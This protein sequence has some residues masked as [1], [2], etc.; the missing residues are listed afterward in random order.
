MAAATALLDE[1]HNPLQQNSRDHNTYTLGRIGRHNVVL[2]CLPTGVAGTLSAARVANQMLRT[3]EGIRFGLMVGIGGGVPSEEN[4]IRL[5]DIVVSKPT[6]QSGGVIQYDF[7]KTVQDGRFERTGSLKRPPDVLLTALAN[8]QSKHMMEGHELAKYL[9]EMLRRYPKMA[10]QFALPDMQLDSLYDAEY[11]HIKEYATCSQCNVSRLMD[12]EPRPSEDPFIH[13]GLIAS[14]DQVMRDG[15][16]RER[17]RK[18]LDV[19]CFEMEAAGLMDEFPCLVVRGICDY[20]DSHKN[21]QWQGYAA[22]TAAAYAKEL[23]SVIT[24]NLVVSTCAAVETTKS[25]Y[26]GSEFEEDGTIIFEK[27][28]QR[29]GNLDD[30]NNAISIGEEAVSATPLD[31]P[32]RAGRLSN[33]AIFRQSRFEQTR[34]L[35]DLNNAISIGEEAVSATPLDHPNRAGRLSNLAVFR[36]SRFELTGNF[37]DLQ[38]A[39]SRAKEAVSATPLDHPDR[40]RMLTNLASLLY[41]RYNRSGTLSDLQD[42]IRLAQAAVDATTEDH[43]DRARRLTNLASLL[44]GRYNRSGTLSDLQDAIRL[45]RAAVDHPDRATWLSNLGGL[46]EYRYQRTGSMDD[47]EEAISLEQAVV[48]ATAKDGTD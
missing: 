43:P 4:D 7:G 10:T 16:T 47:L 9:C 25:S 19:L 21:K 14:G 26:R 44:Y 18:E 42:A 34:N 22:A 13:Y 11:D 32:N 12:R 33:L 29:A 5:G 45:V 1:R 23:L 39:I 6:G 3:F 27:R 30:L 15:A 36:Q 2:A 35:D 31:H 17:L 38:S 40:A 28:F 8:L 41:S 46:L 37:D 20:A 48:N 24:G